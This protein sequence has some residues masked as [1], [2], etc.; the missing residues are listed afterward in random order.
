MKISIFT[1]SYNHAAYIEQTIQSV[2][3]QD[4]ENLEYIV[5]DDGS[6][7][8]SVS[9]IKKYSKKLKLI[10]QKNSGQVKTMNRGLTATTGEIVGCLNSDDVLLPG[11]LQKVLQFFIDNPDAKWVTGDY[12]VI[13]A[14]N[15]KIHR[16]IPLYKKLLSIFP[17]F[18]MLCFT[19]FIPQPSTFWRREIIE[20]IGIFDETL[21]YTMDYDYWFRIMQKYLLYKLNTPLSA[22]RTHAQSKGGSEYKAELH[23]QLM[24]A[25]RYTDKKNILF[26]HKLH[27]FLIEGTFNIIKSF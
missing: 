27:N 26:L 18:S 17:T 21:N 14:K 4:V 8:E 3:N 10:I 9:I 6:S 22:F 2:L 25:K 23:E 19:N 1:T 5:V 24:T 20:T 16:Y 13:D 15:K 11:A 12:F 7:D